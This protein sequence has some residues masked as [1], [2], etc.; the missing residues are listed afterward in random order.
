MFYATPSQAS[1]TVDTVPPDTSALT[2][3]TG[4]INDATPTYTFTNPDGTGASFECEVDAT[5]FSTCTSPFTP[6]TLSDGAHT[7]SVRSKDAAGN[8]DA[9]PSQASI[10]VDTVPPDTSALTGPTGLINDATP[11]YTFTNP[12]GTG[13]SFECR[14]RCDRVLDLHEPVHA[15]HAER[16]RPHHLGAVAEDAAGNVDATPS[17]AVTVDT[18]PPNTSAL[19]GPSGLTNDNTPTYTFT[20][21]DG[22]GASFECDVDGGGFAACTSPVICAA[23]G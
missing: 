15:E 23:P 3:P 12:D 11:T 1:I 8:V 10:T 7:I 17:A 22:T 14:G 13:A 9:T 5:G 19:T 16:R 21:P 6:S 20:N 2:G 18:T 4:L